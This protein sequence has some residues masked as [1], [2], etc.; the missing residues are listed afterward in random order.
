[1]VMSG[2]SQVSNIPSGMG[3]M[4]S[5]PMPGVPAPQFHS[6]RP[7]P[8]FINQSP[9]PSPNS[10]RHLQV[11]PQHV[12]YG[13]R[14]QSPS[15]HDIL[16]VPGQPHYPHN[17]QSMSAVS[18]YCAS[19][20]TTTITTIAKSPTSYS[21]SNSN[22]TGV[23][24]PDNPMY[25]N[26]MPQIS[27][28]RMP[29]SNCN[30]AS[31]VKPTLENQPA[32][33]QCNNSQILNPSP[34]LPPG[35]Q[36]KNNSN[37]PANPE[38]TVASIQ[39]GKISGLPSEFN[40]D[41][42]LDERMDTGGSFMQ[43]LESCSPVVSCNKKKDFEYSENNATVS[44]AALQKKP[45][46][47]LSIPQNNQSASFAQAPSQDTQ[48]TGNKFNTIQTNVPAKLSPNTMASQL[49]S[50]TSYCVTTAQMP[51]STPS[52]SITTLQHQDVQPLT[53][54]VGTVGGGATVC[55][56]T[57]S[58]SNVNPAVAVNQRFQHR[59]PG[60]MAIQTSY[61]SPRPPFSMQVMCN[62]E[63][64]VLSFW[65]SLQ[66]SS[67]IQDHV[68]QQGLPSRFPHPAQQYG[69]PRFP[70]PA[71]PSQI[72]P[73]CHYGPRNDPRMQMHPGQPYSVYNHH[74]MQADYARPPGIFYFYSLVVVVIEKH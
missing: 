65:F 15:R 31:I 63:S 8:H 51:V 74:P 3:V 27:P 57:V 64:L 36:V 28:Q 53:S 43:Q 52:A 60:P 23:L 71:G 62:L 55:S 54:L 50:S 40:L 25:G 33:N 70:V 22:S 16:A 2:H 6:E 32:L 68:T 44:T 47:N 13:Y 38:P 30:N 10:T 26:K 11:S 45:E 9:M 37:V 59:M 17:P 18:S 12:S 7:R 1:M 29:V 4:S 42:L 41:S 20:M 73:P 39:Q 61:R 72:M 24:P 46:S 48:V 56:A 35:Q 5:G 58:S 19:T 69:D 67:R 66:L 49:M 34:I 14:Q 21:M